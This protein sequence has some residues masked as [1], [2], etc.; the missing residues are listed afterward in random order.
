ML[1]Q[2]GR[3]V[4]VVS[5]KCTDAE[6]VSLALPSNYAFSSPDAL[7]AFSLTEGSP[8]FER[9]LTAAAARDK[10]EVASL[11]STGQRPGL[12]GAEVAGPFIKATVLWVAVGYTW[13]RRMP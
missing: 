9:M 11:A 7:L 4:G 3:V 6:G 1:D 8:A 5:M 2:Q 12:I 10:Q 13:R